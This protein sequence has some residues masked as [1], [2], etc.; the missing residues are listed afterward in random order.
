MMINTEETQNEF[1]E[2]NDAELWTIFSYTISTKKTFGFIE[3]LLV[4]L[5]V[6]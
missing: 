6:W 2:V 1:F 3:T 4:K 5:L